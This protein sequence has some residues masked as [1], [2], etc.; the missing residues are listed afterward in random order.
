MRVNVYSAYARQVVVTAVFVMGMRLPPFMTNCALVMPHVVEVDE[1]A[2]RGAVEV[3]E[4]GEPLVHIG[5]IGA[6]FGLGAVREREFHV[7]RV[8]QGVCD[9][10]PVHGH[11]RIAERHMPAGIHRAGRL[12]LCQMGDR[13]FCLQLLL[14]AFHGGFEGFAID[15]LEQI[16]ARLHLVAEHREIGAGRDEDDRAVVVLIA[17]QPRYVQSGGGMR[18]ILVAEITVEQQQVVTAVLPAFDERFRVGENVT[19]RLHGIP[20]GGCADVPAVEVFRAHGGDQFA[21]GRV[22][23]DD[24][25]AHVPSLLCRDCADDVP[26]LLPSVPGE[27][28]TGCRGACVSCQKSTF[29]AIRRISTTKKTRSIRNGSFRATP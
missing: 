6:D 14:D 18:Q 27:G 29:R 7:V 4:H 11:G 28:N 25:D 12:R 22:I 13:R 20:A 2:S 5:E 15:G 17:Q 16:T 21:F 19:D 10:P 3:V 9:E 26:A 23:L 1:H 8:G 24:G